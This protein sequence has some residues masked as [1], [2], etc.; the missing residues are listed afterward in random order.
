MGKKNI[1]YEN[2]STA[3]DTR[4]HSAPENTEHLEQTEAGTY[5]NCLSWV[6]D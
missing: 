3:C 4:W 5:N 1:K 6:C 2:W